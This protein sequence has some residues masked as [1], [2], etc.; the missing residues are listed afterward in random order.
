VLQAGSCFCL[1]CRLGRGYAALH[2]VLLTKSP[3]TF[4]KSFSLLFPSPPVLPHR[5]SEQWCSWEHHCT[6]CFQEEAAPIS[7]GWECHQEVTLSLWT[8]RHQCSQQCRLW[9]GAYGTRARAGVCVC[10]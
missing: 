1:L 10:L 9:V 6:F 2:P 5:K 3:V 8:V 4:L 7:R